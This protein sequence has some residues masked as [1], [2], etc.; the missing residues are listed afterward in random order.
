MNAR[1]LIVGLLFAG[2]AFAQQPQWRAPRTADGHPDLQG[3]WTSATI[4]PLERPDEFGGRR[5]LT[6]E[7]TARLEDA[8]ASLVSN[9]AQADRPEAGAA[10]RLQGLRPRLRLQQF[11]AR[12]R[13]AGRDDRRREAHLAADR[14]AGRQDSAAHCRAS[15]STWRQGAADAPEL[16]WTGST[17]ARRALPAGVRLELRSAD[18]AGAV[19]QPLPDRAEQGRGHD[20]GGDGAR[21]AHRSPRRQARREQ[22]AQMDGRFHRTL[23]RRHAGRRDHEL[24]RLRKLSRHDSRT[25]A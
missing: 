13:L 14:S 2:A 5:A 6:A 8:E 16:R 7:E 9:S 4:T 17:A 12:S 25:H 23:G 20:P 19:Q 21:R 3:I 10:R 15:A 22:R 18:A 24:H 11:L 1:V